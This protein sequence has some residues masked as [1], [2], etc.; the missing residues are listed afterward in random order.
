M[1][2]LLEEPWR[3]L[4]SQ[5]KVVALHAEA[6][7]RYSQTP[8]AIGA[9]ATDCVDGKLGNAWTSE[10]YRVDEE[11]KPGICFAGFLL[12]YLVVGNCFPD[13]NKRVGWAAAMSVLASLGLTVKAT[14]EE[15]IGLVRSIADDYARWAPGCSMDRI[16][17]NGPIS[18]LYPFTCIDGI[19]TM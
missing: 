1:I 6:I 16:S 2:E 5:E 13:G 8:L 4:I 7:L 12:F 14:N 18:K 19:I 17:P 3:S 11:A 9:H 15:A 10:G